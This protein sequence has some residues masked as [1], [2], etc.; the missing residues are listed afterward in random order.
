MKKRDVFVYFR[1]LTGAVGLNDDSNLFLNICHTKPDVLVV[2]L[3]A[4]KPRWAA[5]LFHILTI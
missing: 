4:G 1:G 5:F 3:A 2:G